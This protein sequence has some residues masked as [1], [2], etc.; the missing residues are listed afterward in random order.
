MNEL[1]IETK[2]IAKRN[3]PF[4]FYARSITFRFFIL[5]GQPVLLILRTHSH[6][7]LQAYQKLRKNQDV[8][9]IN[10]PTFWNYSRRNKNA[11]FP[12]CSV[13]LAMN[14]QKKWRAVLPVPS[15]PPV[16]P[17]NPSAC[18]RSNESCL[19]GDPAHRRGAINTRPC[20][21]SSLAHPELNGQ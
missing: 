5:F 13:L 15:V 21:A 7:L 18:A 1:Q 10:R 17:S 2:R 8:P 14:R 11:P 20:L 9:N 12:F 4:R 3:G 19:S 6:T 16:L